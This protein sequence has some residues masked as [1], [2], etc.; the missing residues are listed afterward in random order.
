METMPRPRRSLSKNIRAVVGSVKPSIQTVSSTSEEPSV[1]SGSPSQVEMQTQAAVRLFLKRA[2]KIT[3][4]Q[5]TRREY[6]EAYPLAF[7]VEVPDLWSE[8]ANQVYTL[9]GDLFR[10]YPHAQLEIEV[11]GKREGG[12]AVTKTEPHGEQ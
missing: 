10:K 5:V 7:D 1:M 12:K 2:E 11:R 4:T 6:G 3:A 9:R 8:A